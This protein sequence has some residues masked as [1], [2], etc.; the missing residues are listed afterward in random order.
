MFIKTGSVL[1]TS[2]THAVAEHDYVPLEPRKESCD[3]SLSDETVISGLEHGPY[4]GF[5]EIAGVY[6]RHKRTLGLAHCSDL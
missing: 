5:V 3:L 6:Q 2:R 1:S 4:V